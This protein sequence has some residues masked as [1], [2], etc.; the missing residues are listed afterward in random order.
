MKK[1]ALSLVLVA[2]VAFVSCKDTAKE[3][4]EVEATANEAVEAVEETAVE[5]ISC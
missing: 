2:S 1:L 4:F 5:A 3:A